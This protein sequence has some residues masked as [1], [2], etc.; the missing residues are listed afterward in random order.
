MT[1]GPDRASNASDKD[2]SM[3]RLM[4]SEKFTLDHLTSGLVSFYRQTQVKR[5]GR[6]RAALG[7]CEVANNAGGPRYYL[8]NESGQEYYGGTWID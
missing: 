3:Y 6:L 4:K 8:L 2:L 5:F 7:A 1:D